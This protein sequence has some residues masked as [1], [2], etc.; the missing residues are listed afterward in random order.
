MQESPAAPTADHPA[1]DWQKTQFTNLIRYVPS[2]TYYARLRVAGKLIRKSLKTDVLSVAKLRL[3]DLDKQ[4]RQRA[5]STDAV[6]RGK[7]TVGDAVAIHQERVAGDASLKLRTKEYH[8]QRI[9]AL[10]IYRHLGRSA[11][12]V[13][14]DL[15]SA[16]IMVHDYPGGSTDG[17]S[18][19]RTSSERPLVLGDWSLTRRANVPKVLRQSRKIVYQEVPMSRGGIFTFSDARD[20]VTR[21]VAAPKRAPGTRRARNAP[22]VSSL[23]RTTL[24]RTSPRCT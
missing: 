14:R 12:A 15:T 10:F 9:V 6:A 4:E 7:M 13:F 1:R 20:F 11:G 2:G 17:G 23:A 22:S 16:V 3:G 21:G 8:A 18:R 5:E 19:W 24:P